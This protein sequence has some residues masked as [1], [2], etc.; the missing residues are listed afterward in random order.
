VNL[1]ATFVEIF[2][3]Q[4]LD[5]FEREFRAAAREN[6]PAGWVDRAG[7]QAILCAQQRQAGQ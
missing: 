3:E 6:S 4:N 7:T 5:C 2:G 1:C